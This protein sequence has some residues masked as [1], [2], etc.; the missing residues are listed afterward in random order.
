V[1][2][3]L[4]RDNEYFT[5]LRDGDTDHMRQM[6]FFVSL[7]YGDTDDKR[8]MDFFVPYVM[9]ILIIRDGWTS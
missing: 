5:S 7:R 4:I 1:G 3:L 6:D 8:Q 9:G 2:I